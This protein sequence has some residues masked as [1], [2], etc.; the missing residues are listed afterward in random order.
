MANAKQLIEKLLEGSTSNETGKSTVREDCSAKNFNSG[1][2]AFV[3]GKTRQANPFDKGTREHNQ[4]GLGF[5]K[6]EEVSKKARD[7]KNKVTKK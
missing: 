4:W 6:A 3:L 1:K 7:A 5:S 2:K